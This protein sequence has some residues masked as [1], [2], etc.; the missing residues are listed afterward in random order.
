V[1]AVYDYDAAA[2]GELTVRE[3]DVLL[4]FDNEEDWILVQ[5]SQSAGK[6]GYVPGNYVEV[7]DEEES[8]SST[9]RSA[10]IIVPASVSFPAR[11]LIFSLILSQ[12]PRPPYTD[13][14]EKVASAKVTADNIKTWSVSE[15]DKK[16]KKKKGTLGIGSGSLFFASESDKVSVN[17]GPSS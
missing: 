8:K 15:I 17:I 16:G 7:V 1:K 9:S 11:F 5:E 3:D 14:A 6:A 10:R 4:V 2:P 12:P 13:P